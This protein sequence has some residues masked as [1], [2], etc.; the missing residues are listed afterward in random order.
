MTDDKTT[1]KKTPDHPERGQPLS[2]E[3][4]QSGLAP[5]THNDEQDDHRSQAQEVARQA[6]NAASKSAGGTE[7]RKPGSPGVDN[8]AG[9]ETDLI[10][11]MRAMEDTGKIDNSAF[12][13]EPNHDDDVSKYEGKE[14]PGQT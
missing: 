10:D 2:Q 12:A 14:R 5:E 9:E 8:V 1:E 13:G 6:Q 11:E 3:Q 7:S 4:R